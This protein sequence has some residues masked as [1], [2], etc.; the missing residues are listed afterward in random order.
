MTFSTLSNLANTRETPQ[1][2]QALPNQVQNEA[3]G[4]VFELSPKEK[5]NRFLV[6]GTTGG[7]YYQRERNLFKQNLES[8]IDLIKSDGPGVVE[9]TV[10]ISQAGR[11]R[12]NDYA[13][14]VL[15]LCFTHGDTTTKNAAKPALLKVART[16][17]HL[18]HFVSF[19]NNMRGWGSSMRKAVAN[20]FTSKEADVVAFHA[21]KYK[22]RDGWS[23]RD[24]LRIS[25]PRPKDYV[26]ACTYNWITTG[27]FKV[28]D[29]Y[30]RD[31]D[32]ESR[33]LAVIEGYELAQQETSP[34]GM[35][36]LIS[37]YCLTH[38]MIPNSFK[39]SP[40]VW[41]ALLPGMGATAMLR[42]LSKMTSIGLLKPLSTET[43]FVAK[44]LTDRDFIK[45]GRLHPLQI[46]SA[47]LAYKT[48][49]GRN[50]SWIPNL[51]V[52]AALEEAFYL[53]F[54]FIEPSGKNRML[55]I[56]VSGSM[57][58]SLNADPN[59]SC[60]QAAAVMAMVSAR[61]EPNSEI[62]GFSN[63]FVNL[64]ITKHDSLAEVMNKVQSR[65]F[66]STDCA[67]P[68]LHALEQG[69]DVDQF[70]VYTDCETYAGSIH[71]F[72]ALKKYRKAMNKP[73]AKLVVVGMTSTG[74]SIADP[75]DK[76]MMDVVGF[77]TAT[78]GIIS[79]FAAGR[80]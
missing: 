61:K 73:E 5:L 3:G 24:V 38:E 10:S 32:I 57:L 39:D 26:S 23:M 63:T 75:N 27:Q 14:L 62:Y 45:G 21:I 2:E 43:K 53:S 79:E 52:L 40:E 58:S 7:T 78:P 65:T 13:L 12:N 16:G 54:D 59:I 70:E 8:I 51:T 69:L 48:G 50:F 37:K 66:G 6:L 15:A 55:A 67:V 35:Q 19:V 77:D 17:T 1:T 29:Q 68:M 47:M 74:F 46:L 72:Q 20:W 44:H 4:F 80:I 34:W 33:P 42:N 31:L 49:Y 36:S 56:D 22:Q 76:F 71:P 9:Q 28:R 64:G 18:L 60:A 41:A 25:H 30:N 11:A